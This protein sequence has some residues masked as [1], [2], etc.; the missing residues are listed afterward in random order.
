MAGP[1]SPENPASPF[2]AK[3]VMIPEVTTFRTRLLFLSFCF[4]DNSHAYWPNK[5]ACDMYAGKG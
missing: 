5:K 1:P 2:P 3:V 4:Y